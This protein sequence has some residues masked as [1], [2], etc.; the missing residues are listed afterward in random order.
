MLDRAIQKDSRPQKIHDH[1]I[2][3]RDERAKNADTNIGLST[4]HPA[5]SQ[6]LQDSYNAI[7]DILQEI[8]QEVLTSFT[9]PNANLISPNFYN[10]VYGNTTDD[11]LKAYIEDIPRYF[12]NI[13]IQYLVPHVGFQASSYYN[14]TVKVDFQNL[15]N[16]TD[17]E[18]ENMVNLIKERNPRLHLEIASCTNLHL[19]TLKSLL[20]GN[21][22]LLATVPIGVSL[23]NL[24]TK[25]LRK[26]HLLAV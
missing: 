4:T 7:M 1:L 14:Q 13:Y 9:K 24:L 26:T 19:P 5:Y 6:D 15:T 20:W 8:R 17:A 10:I 21:R 16:L 2:I 25:F 22:G 12:F 18:M 3:M 11:A 23:S